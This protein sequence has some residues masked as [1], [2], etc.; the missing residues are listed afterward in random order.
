MCV[1]VSLHGRGGGSIIEADR[2]IIGREG[3]VYGTKVENIFHR[4]HSEHTTRAT[5]GVVPASQG[6]AAPIGERP[7]IT[8][9]YRYNIAAEM[10]VTRTRGAGAY[11][12]K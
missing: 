6:C 4:A 5:N 3:S 9:E 11:R 10:T 2:K 1:C 8:A 7:R 12:Q